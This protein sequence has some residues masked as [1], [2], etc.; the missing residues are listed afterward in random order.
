MN[1]ERG[2]TESALD[3]RAGTV[4]RPTNARKGIVPGSAFARGVFERPIYR[5]P[6]RPR[7]SGRIENRT[8]SST[9]LVGSGVRSCKTKP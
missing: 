2:D 1:P 7:W 6:N 9:K 4:S 8:K 5:P 3:F